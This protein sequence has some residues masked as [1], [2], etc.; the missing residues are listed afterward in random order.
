MRHAKPGVRKTKLPFYHLV[1]AVSNC[2][3][4][5][6]LK[7]APTGGESVYFLL[8]ST[9]KTLIALLAFVVLVNSSLKCMVKEFHTSD[10]ERVTFFIEQRRPSYLLIIIFRVVWKDGVESV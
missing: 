1:G 3:Y 8:E 6:R 5:V 10:K 2:A 9:I 7:T 4:A